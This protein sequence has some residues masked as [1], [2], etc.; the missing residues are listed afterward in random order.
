MYRDFEMVDLFAGAGG[1]SE[2]ARQA[3]LSMGRRPKI[4]AINHDEVAVAT[5]RLNLP[6]SVVKC[7]GVDD[8][9][10]RKW[11]GDRRIHLLWA[12]PECTNHSK[13]KAGKPKDDQSRATAYCVLRWV[14]AMHPRTV[15]IEN[16]AEFMQWGPLDENEEVIPERK[17]EIFDVYLAAFRAH[18]Y[19]VDYKIL[20]A[21]DYG[22]PTIRER[23]IIQ[24]QAPG[25]EIRWPEPTHTETGENGTLPWGVTAD[26]VNW[27]H[28]ME[29]AFKRRSKGGGPLADK[30]M[31]RI[32]YGLVRYGLAPFLVP[33][34]SGHHVRGLDEPFQTVVTTSRGEGLAVPYVVD[35]AH[36]NS[37]GYRCHSLED[38]FSTCTARGGKGLAMPYVV[39]TDHTGNGNKFK[40]AKSLNVPFGT[41]VTKQNMGLAVPYIVYF[42]GKAERNTVARSLQDPAPTVTAGGTHMALCQ[43]VPVYRDTEHFIV[44]AGGMEIRCGVDFRMFQP[45]ELQLVQGFPPSYRFLG[46][47]EQQVKQIGNAVPCGMARAAVAAACYD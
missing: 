46:T 42:R 33:Q 13:A 3:L 44:H 16:V 35:T 34:Q 29:S 2:G 14:A 27:D 7:S 32:A 28:P 17:G 24:A 5:H 31:K 19:T 30:T 38:L 6:D 11:L 23:L 4:H 1:T 20:R 18:G 25:R 8:V 9:D 36:G 10:P 37:G 22:D 26:C 12:S 40:G 21:K 47:K 43:P 45:D 15:L 39:Q 41:V